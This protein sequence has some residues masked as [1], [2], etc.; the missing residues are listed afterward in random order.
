MKKI[1]ICTNKDC[2]KKHKCFIYYMNI[3]NFKE[4]KDNKDIKVVAFYEENCIN[5]IEKKSKNN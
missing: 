2:K 3:P 1:K 4:I 5:F